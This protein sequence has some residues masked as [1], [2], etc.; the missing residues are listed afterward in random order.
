MGFTFYGDLLGISGYYKL[1]PK[2]AKDKL[3]AFYNTVFFSLSEYCHQHDDVHV[4]MFSDSMLFYGDDA[5]P[6]LEQLQR[7]YVKLIH[8]GL[9]LRG[10]IVNG[11]QASKFELSSVTLKKNWRMMIPLHAQLV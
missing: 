9:L 8:K 1:S 5:I 7:V 4:H 2:I 10:A 11:K 6:A 3:D